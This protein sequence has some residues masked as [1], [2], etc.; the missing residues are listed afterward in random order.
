MTESD[1]HGL[2]AHAPGAKLDAL[3][4]RPELVQRGF[5]NA[6][7]CVTD[8]ATYGAVKYTPDGWSQVDDGVRRYTDAL[9]RHLSSH[10]RGETYDPDTGLHHL[11]HAAWNALAVLEL[12]TREE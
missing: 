7:A 2:D 8:V 11:S 3:K 12:I 4:P 1:P 6:L 5:A 9:Y 10:H